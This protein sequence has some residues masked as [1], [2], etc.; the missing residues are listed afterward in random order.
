[1]RLVDRLIRRDG[2][3]E[4]MASGAAILTTSYGSPDREPVMPQLTGWAQRA[5]GSNAPVFAAVLVRMALFSEVTFQ[6]Q[7]KDDKHLFGN[8]A[9]AKLE[10]PFGPGST[11]QQLLA[12]MEQDVSL[13]GNAFIWD[14]PAPGP[15]VRLR[16]DWTTII[17]EVI[18]VDGG[19]YR[20]PAGYWFEPPRGAT[21]GEQPPGFFIPADEVAHWAP[22]PDPQ[23]D[24]RG[25]SWL[26]PVMRDIQGDDGL[27]VYKIKYLSNN[28]SPNLLIKY[29]Q[30]LQP[31]TVDSIRERMQARY[32]GPDNAF[33]TLVL[34]QG[35]DATVIGNSLAQMNFDGVQSAGAE[36]I[37]AA[38]NVPAVLVG[39]EPLRGAGRGYQESMQKFS[40]IYARPQWRSACATLAKLTD[41]PA[42]NRL[43]FDTSDVAALQDGEME[44]GQ[45]VLVKSQAVLALNQAAKYDPD[46]IIAAVNSGDLT[47]LKPL[48]EPPP[49]TA[50][51][52]KPVQHMLPQ[53]QPGATAEPL[54]SSMPRIPVGSTS[55]GD[56][57]NGTRPGP[58]PASARRSLN[59]AGHD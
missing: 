52:G 9:L 51:P 50:L 37:L 49:L 2:Y 47:Q 53:A 39:L 38:A 14:A 40:N 17:S 57:G 29:A 8:P 25:M 11:T 20:Q 26:T 56:G 27:S 22:V 15:L 48:P 41:V 34:D 35:A 16:P 33:K 6:F 54:P 31:G 18:A 42:G 19:W 7:A 55:P 36:R 28:A 1:M 30:K 44:R 23:A 58:R 21:A 32:G 24:F 5:N 4:G 45:T 13:A 3:W 46:S 12:R 10:Q 43:W 59:G